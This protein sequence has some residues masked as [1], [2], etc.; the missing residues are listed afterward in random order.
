M[1]MAGHSSSMTSWILITFLLLLTFWIHQSKAR[2]HDYFDTNIWLPDLKLDLTRNVTLV[3]AT[4][5]KDIILC[6]L[7]NEHNKT[8]KDDVL[9]KVFNTCQNDM[10]Q[11]F[12]ENIK[13]EG[14]S[15]DKISL[16]NFLCL[17]AKA[18]DYPE[19]CKFEPVCWLYSEITAP[20][21]P[22]TSTSVTSTPTPP[23]STTSM[24]TTPPTSTSATAT[25]PT[26]ATATP[27][28]ATPPTSAT[29]TL[30]TS[31]TATLPTSTQTILPTST[32]TILPTSTQTI[33]PTSAQTILPTSAQTTLPPPPPST[34][35]PSTTLSQTTTATTTV[36]QSTYGNA[37]Y[38]PQKE[39]ASPKPP[40]G[41]DVTL[42]NMFIIS[43]FLNLVLPLAVYL[44]MRTKIQSETPRVVTLEPCND[45]EAQPMRGAESSS[46]S[47]SI[48]PSANTTRNGCP[49]DEL[50]PH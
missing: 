40:E 34:V 7:K 35:L 14:E 8:T 48:R 24:P 12:P 49:P 22:P 47:H 9:Y 45:A 4:N 6:T 20:T 25:L 23:T 28:T 29:A 13:C 1:S 43:L 19:G 27:P 50:S 11:M 15:D 17:T 44:W 31:A 41:P 32:Q 42:R 38:K 5:A 21:T 3:N 10:P 26:S 2:C 30:P 16:Y 46:E 36:L 39:T 37:S 18:F 33:L